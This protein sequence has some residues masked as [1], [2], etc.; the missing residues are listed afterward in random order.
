MGFG[1]LFWFERKWFQ[2][3]W[4]WYLM[5]CSMLQ[6]INMTTL[7]IFNQLSCSYFSQT[8][9]KWNFELIS[10]CLSK[11]LFCNA[12]KC[13]RHQFLSTR[14]LLLQCLVQRKMPKKS[15]FSY[16]I[17]CTPLVD[18]GEQSSSSSVIK[19]NSQSSNF[20]KKREGGQVL[21]YLK[22]LM[23]FWCFLLKVYIL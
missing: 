9:K 21:L 13:H 5:F 18:R 20:Q 14:G 12:N 7:S 8:W 10:I 17:G 22:N 6:L 11:V 3:F 1:L 23:W 2:A 4:I 15:I 19:L 16:S